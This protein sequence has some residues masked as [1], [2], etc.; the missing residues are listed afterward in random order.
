VIYIKDTNYTLAECMDSIPKNRTNKVQWQYVRIGL[1]IVPAGVYVQGH[2]DT[3]SQIDMNYNSTDFCM[4]FSLDRG[5]DTLPFITLNK[6]NGLPDKRSIT[7]GGSDTVIFKNKSA[8][9]VT[10]RIAA[11][12]AMGIIIPDKGGVQTMKF[13]SDYDSML[14]KIQYVDPSSGSTVVSNGREQLIIGHAGTLAALTIQFPNGPVNGQIFN[15][16]FDDVIT[17]LTLTAPGMTI[18]AP[19][20]TVSGASGYAWVFYNAVWHKRSN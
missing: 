11:T 6:S 4:N 5:A 7:L 18:K 13:L 9:K 20:T 8:K 3:A 17:T 2:S 16:S 14:V 15:I 19:I 10:W 1:F 12:T